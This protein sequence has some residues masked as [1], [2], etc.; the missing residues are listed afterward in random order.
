MHVGAAFKRWPL[1]VVRRS[2]LLLLLAWLP[3]LVYVGHWDSL[4]TPS[5]AHAVAHAGG[6]APDGSHAQHCHGGFD[7]CSGS[8]APA[9]ALTHGLEVG[10]APVVSVARPAAGDDRA[11]VG[12]S[13]TPILPPP[14]AAV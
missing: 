13:M 6:A 4:A 5:A 2:A 7:R 11:L 10:G 8:E 12:H 3:S 9:P 1:A 14:R